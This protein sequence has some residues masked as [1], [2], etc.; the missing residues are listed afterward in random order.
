MKEK[1]K[2][3]KLEKMTLLE[4]WGYLE[5]QVKKENAIKKKTRNNFTRY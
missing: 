4:L 2:N 5:K 1:I 3:K